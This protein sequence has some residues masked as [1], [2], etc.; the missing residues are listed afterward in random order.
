MSHRQL[1]FHAGQMNIWGNAKEAQSKARP[2]IKSHIY[3]SKKCPAWEFS[4]CSCEW[5]ESSEDISISRGSPAGNFKPQHCPYSGAKRPPASFRGTYHA[6]FTA[7]AI[8]NLPLPL[9]LRL[10]DGNCS[11][12]P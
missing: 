10:W 2:G 6:L 9:N 12:V 1:E 3:A 5:Q 8:V 7:K 11:P 4:I